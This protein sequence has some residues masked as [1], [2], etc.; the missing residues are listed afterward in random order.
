MG[1]GRALGNSHRGLTGSQRLPVGLGLAIVPAGGHGHGRRCPAESESQRRSSKYVPPS[2]HC[3][4]PTVLLLDAG[5]GAL[6]VLVPGLVDAPGWTIFATAAL[7]VVGHNWPVFLGFRGGHR[8]PFSMP[9]S[10]SYRR[11]MADGGVE[12]STGC[13]GRRNLPSQLPQGNIP[14][15]SRPAVA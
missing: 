15:G 3:W 7:V 9:G 11:R 13:D 10:D 12:R 4:G 14:P 6:A 5:K 8:I 1:N 2:G